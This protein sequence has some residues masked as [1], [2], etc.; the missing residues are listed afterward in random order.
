M[1]THS[2]ET[3]KT[4]AS[5]LS[6]I[7]L[8]FDQEKLP[9]SPGQQYDSNIPAQRCTVDLGNGATV[10]AF[11]VTSNPDDVYVVGGGRFSTW[12]F[13]V[14]DVEP[15][16][17]AEVIGTAQ[18]A[19]RPMT[20]WERREKYHGRHSYH[21]YG[22]RSK[23]LPPVSES[24]VTLDTYQAR[25]GT[26]E[27]HYGYSARDNLPYYNIPVR[28]TVEDVTTEI[29]LKFCGPTKGTIDLANAANQQGTI[30]T[31]TCDF[32]GTHLSWTQD[33]ADVNVLWGLLEHEVTGGTT[34][35]LWARYLQPWLNNQKKVPESSLKALKK[36]KN[37]APNLERLAEEQP[38]LWAYFQALQH[39]KTREKTTNNKLLAAFL[40]EHGP[41][42]DDLVEHLTASLNT[43]HTHTL[44]SSYSGND[45]VFRNVCLALPGAQAVVES[46]KAKDQWQFR[47][48]MEDQAEGLGLSV[49][50]FPLLMEAVGEG[51]IPMGVFHE[52]G[53]KD[54]LVNVEFDLWERALDRGWLDVIS[55]IAKNASGRGTYTHQMTSYLAFLFKIEKYL[56]RHAPRPDSSWKAIPKYVESQWELEMGEANEEGTVKRRSALTPVVDNEAGTIMVPYAAMAI[57]G[58]QTTYCYSHNYYVVE[59]GMNDPEGKGVFSKDLEEGLNGRDDYGL[60]W[61]TLTGTSRNTGYPTFLIIFERTVRHGTRVHFHRVHPSRKRGPKGTPTPAS[62]MIAECYRYMAGN[63]KV[64]EI[65]AQQGDLIFIKTD[66]PGKAVEEPV[67]VAAFE[68]HAFVTPEGNPPAQLIRSVAKAPVNRL[69]YLYAEKGF[70]V[71]HPEHE[72]LPNEKMTGGWYEVRRCKSWEANPTAVWSL[73]ID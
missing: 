45:P 65:H 12:G 36:R 9:T 14:D 6:N 42:Y 16:I 55:G 41:N 10:R 26:W 37:I 22:W 18:K 73:T 5:P 49:H 39:D 69:G 19:M 63:V 40:K 24:D 15:F 60:M 53:N 61:Y 34:L 11:V 59:E 52:P 57:Y 33:V 67:A 7:K 27:C 30:L 43:A 46:Q 58:R 35:D 62:R 44:W 68:G 50:A 31:V 32:F 29:E 38:L 1:H 51:H 70:I 47:K 72:P 28:I 4:T 3:N 66:G 13:K 21:N 54:H 20:E 71:D 23:P 56:N 48:T 64:S 8:I 25:Y 17:T 2:P